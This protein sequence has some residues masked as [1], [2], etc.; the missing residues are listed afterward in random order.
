MEKHGMN[1][2]KITLNQLWEAAQRLYEE[3]PA[4]L[5]AAKKTLF[6]E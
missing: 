3:Y 1:Y 6:G 2:A 4:L 5:D